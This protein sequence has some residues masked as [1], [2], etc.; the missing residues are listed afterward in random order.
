MGY[1]MKEVEALSTGDSTGD[2]TDDLKK[3]LLHL[4]QVIEDTESKVDNPE[5]PFEP[6]V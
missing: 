6:G 4:A 5:E 2:V 1:L 3:V